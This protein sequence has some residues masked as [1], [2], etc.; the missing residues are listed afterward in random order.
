M[1]ASD[2]GDAAGMSVISKMTRVFTVL[3]RSADLTVAQLSEALD[4]PVTSVYRIVRHLEGIGWVEKGPQ[5]GQYRLGIDLAAIAEAVESSL[6][7]RQL[8]SPVLAV[9][10]AQTHESAYLCVPHD[11]RAVCIERYDGAFIQSAEL[12]LGGS[13]PLHRGAGSLAILAFEPDNVRR[14]YIA[15]LAGADPNP[16]TAADAHS[17]QDTIERVRATGIAV[18]DG[19]VTPGI[20]TAAAPVF[21]HR[22]A[23][24]GSISLSGLRSRAEANEIDFVT[25]VSRAGRTVSTG[26]GY[27]A[28]ESA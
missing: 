17:L 25:L 24:V 21:D 10:N 2:D 12:P 18:S 13:L 6:D 11:R 22:G 14:E 8:A 5:R 9:L 27:V 26:L 15:A 4:E 16:F 19:D 23:V 20:S 28:E 1:A 7:I 3:S